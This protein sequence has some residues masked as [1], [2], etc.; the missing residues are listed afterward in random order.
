MATSRGRAH[1]EYSVSYTFPGGV[2]L[3]GDGGSGERFSRLENLYRDYDGGGGRYVE[4][5][6]GYRRAATFGK[7]IH[8]IYPKRCKDGSRALVVHAKDLLAIVK[9]KDDNSTVSVLNACRIADRRSSAYEHGFDIYVLDGERIIKVGDTEATVV[10][11]TECP[12]YVPTRYRTGVEY[13]QRNLLSDEIYEEYLIASADEL[14]FGSPEMYYRITDKERRLCALCGVSNLFVAYNI[15]IPS[16]TT[17]SGEKYRVNEIDDGAFTA[18]LNIKKIVIGEGMTR[19]GKKAFSDC[20]ALKEVI[21]PETL[22]EIDSNAFLRCTSLESIL[23]GSGLT[24][25]GGG[26]FSGCTSLKTVYYT[27]RLDDFESISG[28]SQVDSSLLVKHNGIYEVYVEIPIFSKI[29]SVIS[30]NID[31]VDYSFDHVQRNGRI[32]GALISVANKKT[33]EGK[34]ATV[35]AIAKTEAMT[36]GLSPTDMAGSAVIHGCTVSCVFGGRVFLSGNPNHPGTVFYTSLRKD[37]SED[38]TY[39]GAYNHFRDGMGS[40]NVTS[41]ISVGDYLAVFKESGATDGAIYCHTEKETESELIP[42]IYPVSYIHTGICAVGDAMTFYDDPVFIAKGGVSAIEKMTL[43]L[44]RSIS[45]RSHNVN[46]RLLAESLPDARLASWRGYLVLAV[47]CRIYLADSRAMFRHHSGSYE[48][49]WYILDGIGAPDT[50]PE[51]V[52]RYASIADEGYAV[53]S[54]PDTVAGSTVRSEAPNGKINYYT[55]EDGVKYAVYRSEE[56]TVKTLSPISAV[57]S[58]DDELLFFGTAN[59]AL[60][61][62]NSDKRGT[63]PDHIKSMSD[64]DEEDYLASYGGRIH[65]YFYSFENRAPRYLAAGPIDNCG[66][67]QFE[68]ST[69]K[70]SLS[71]KCRARGDG[72]IKVEVYTGEGGYEEKALLPNGECDFSDLNFSSLSFSADE[73]FTVPVKEKEKGWIEKQIVVSSEGFRAPIAVNGISYRFLVK[74]K[75]KNK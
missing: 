53:H 67:P 47:G 70:G 44:A 30:V 75:I 68:K 39:F 58:V 23:V 24:Y 29:S 1:G 16:Y 54:T 37:G 11:S 13:E 56:I 46:P 26:A 6:P 10:G 34:M 21:C 48:Y 18:C 49:E 28:H 38:P 32:V 73:H 61:L 9:L 15:T 35:R 64:Y 52:Y 72:A 20:S 66:I 31:G 59:G 42:R 19:I 51:Y 14:L 25:L 45:I 12:T 65:P 5:I 55:F 3:S 62:F 4:S 41:M 71:L 43:D 50:D 69:V 57:A 40:S 60:Y 8:A 74:G 36:P 63:A 27:A 22:T 2:D 33:I 17:I 7:K